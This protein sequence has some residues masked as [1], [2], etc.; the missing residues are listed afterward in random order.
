[1]ICFS[2]A[3]CVVDITA[4]NNIEYSIWKYPSNYNRKADGIKVVG[5]I[6]DNKMS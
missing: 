4:C 2:L 1:M 3:V 6:G 5:M